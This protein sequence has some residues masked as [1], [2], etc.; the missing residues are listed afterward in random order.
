MNQVIRACCRPEVLAEP[1]YD[2]PLLACYV[3]IN[4]PVV[5]RT[6]I[7]ME[8]PPVTTYKPDFVVYGAFSC[9]RPVDI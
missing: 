8:E 9:C 3:S 2:S 4:T 5:Y 1:S 7:G 6:P